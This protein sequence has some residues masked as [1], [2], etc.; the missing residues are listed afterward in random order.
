MLQANL[1]V[2]R[3]Q[4]ERMRV[5]MEALLDIRHQHTT[6]VNITMTTI[7]IFFFILPL[8]II[9]VLFSNSH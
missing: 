3:G 9:S 1:S 4:L 6:I 5:G 7:I 8:I 2:V